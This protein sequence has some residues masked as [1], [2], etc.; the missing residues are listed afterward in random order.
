MGAA[1]RAAEKRP[2]EDWTWETLGSVNGREMRLKPVC[3]V[4]NNTPQ[5]D[6]DGK[7]LCLFH[8]HM[9]PHYNRSRKP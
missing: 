7:V 6:R 3:K 1:G 8:M 4:H 5:H 2:A 9:K